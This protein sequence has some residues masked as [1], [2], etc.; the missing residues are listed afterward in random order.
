MRIII[1]TLQNCLFLRA[2]N[3]IPIEGIRYEDMDAILH[4]KRQGI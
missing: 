3:C 2:K 1:H 4:N